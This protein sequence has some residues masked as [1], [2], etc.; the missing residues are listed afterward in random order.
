M[1]KLLLALVV[2]L[3]TG[4]LWLVPGA[5][6][7][8]GLTAATGGTN[9]SADT[10]AASPGTGTYTN[11]TGPSYQESSGGQLSTGKVVLDAPAGFQFRTTSV[12]VAQS[13]GQNMKLGSAATC[14][15]PS[16]SITVTPTASAITFWICAQSNGS[17]NA[18]IT[19]SGV[20]VRPANGTPLASAGNIVLDA[21]ST[22]S[23]SGVTA[24]TTSWGALSE[25]ASAL[26]HLDLAPATATKAPGVTQAY[27]ATGRDQFNNS[28]GDMTAT[29]TFTIA[30]GT[31]STSNCSSTAAG[32]H[33]VTG[34]KTGKTGTATLTVT[35]GPTAGITLTPSSSS[36]AAGVAETYTA[37][38][39]DS[40]GNSTGNVTAATS[41]SI[42]GGT[43]STNACSSTA[44]GNHTVTGTHSPSGATATATLTVTTG[45][46]HHITVSP[47]TATKQA[48]AAQA[49]TASSF[50]QYNNFIADVTA[51]TSFSVAGGTCS[52]NS[53]S[54]TTAGDHTVT[55]DNGGG[56]TATATLTVTP[57]P[58]DHIAISPTSSTKAAGVAQAYTATGFDQYGNTTGDVTGATTFSVA[59][60]TCSTNSCSST[61]AGDHTVT[62]DNGGGR[63]ATATLTVTPGPIHHI[64]IS[65]TSS[66]KAAGVAQAYTATGFDQYGNTTGDVTGATTFSV[67][68]GT[69]S[70]NS[71]SSTTAG[72]HTVTADNGGGR[73]ATATLTVTPGPVASITVDVDPTHINADGAS[74]ATATAHVADIYGNP[75]S[76]E[77][78]T[79]STDGDVSFGAVTDHSDGT[80]T[81]TITASTTPGTETI[82]A[83]DGTVSGST[84][85]AERGLVTITSLSRTSRGQGARNQPITITGSGFAGGATV[86][87]GPDTT[88]LSS[89]VVDATRIDVNIN[90]E[91]TAST[92]ARD[93]S[94]QNVD[95]GSAT[96][97]GCFTISPG[98][99]IAS[100]SPSVLGQRAKDELVTITG[101]NFVTG[102]TVEIYGGVTIASATVVDSNHINV[103]VSGVGSTA[104]VGYHEVVVRNK[105]QGRASNTSSFSVSTGPTVTS[106]TPAS[107]KKGATNRDVTVYG[108]DFQPGAVFSFGAGG[109]GVTIN[110]TT[111]VSATEVRLNVSVSPTTGAKARNV[112]VLN[113]DRGRGYCANCF[114]VTA[115]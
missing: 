96:C 67:A 73:T 65:P 71:C 104:P 39:T 12:T 14:S 50:D 74:T 37:N 20:G 25:I 112:D 46:A 54:S 101:N 7:A 17:H 26:H 34:T 8:T 79:F 48:G 92:G 38:G 78:V 69:C 45:P 58:V 13:G 60:G 76:A 51:S 88:V 49:Y 9:I 84:S 115:P 86:S 32:D 53:C 11:L 94:V 82:T 68:G 63:T 30:G 44:V 23:F 33:T 108:T 22:A 97:A 6:A 35:A 81:A 56:R 15:G 100:V 105:D 40:F 47:A 107:L 98:P 27:T 3:I 113:P 4:V 85:L 16:A 18:T 10:A 62:A 41:F 93:V 28:L 19:L 61:A 57:G 83:T 102:A 43:C 66:T 114:T 91:A 89:T 106:L 21:T 75:I 36:K 2:A 95:N 72:D 87:F 24:G 1:K 109:A 55:A 70:T 80:Y 31:C 29:T 111:W 42:A 103:M 64:A 52:T 77:P 110:S 99:S 5:G 90:I 59:G